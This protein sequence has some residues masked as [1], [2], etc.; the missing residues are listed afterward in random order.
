MSRYINGLYVYRYQVRII[1]TKQNLINFGYSN[2]DH[3]DLYFDTGIVLPVRSM[4]EKSGK[5]TVICP[6][7]NLKHSEQA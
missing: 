6:V 2:S 3:A 1:K 5:G 7:L 4:D